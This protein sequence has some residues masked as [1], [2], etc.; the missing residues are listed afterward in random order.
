[1]ECLLTKHNNIK[2]F[3]RQDLGEKLGFTEEE[4]NIIL[5][6]QEKLPILLGGND[7]DAR[8]LWEQ[9][10][11]PQGKFAD[12]VKRKVVDKGFA[13]KEDYEVFLKSAKNCKGGRPTQEYTLTIE[14]AKHV[15]MMENISI[16]FLVRKYLI[17]MQ[18][19]LRKMDGW[20]LVREPEKEGYNK[21]CDVLREQYKKTHDRKDPR[22]YIYSNEADMI[23]RILLGC[24]S[25]K[26]RGKINALDNKTRDHLD[27]EVNKAIY[28]LQN[29][30]IL[31][32]RINKSFAER[33]EILKQLV[34]VD[35]QD[36]VAEIHNLV[37]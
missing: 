12:W 37:A 25:K 36:I 11:E 5:T 30:D 9:L 13:E 1:M 31:L 29:N 3:T 14:T 2:T 17:L 19:A 26:F 22:G 23:N 33:K 24:T 16:G 10:G 35:H 21:L 20:V 32:I 8:P 28:Q 15:A 6:Y 4:T 7:I 34:Q 27:A 18:K